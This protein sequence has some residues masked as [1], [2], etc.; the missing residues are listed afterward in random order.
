MSSKLSFEFDSPLWFPLFKEQ[1]Q[2]TETE[3]N[4]YD[5]NTVHKERR[6]DK[7]MTRKQSY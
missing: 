2:N 1:K 3:K 4:E 5:E 6:K 7:R